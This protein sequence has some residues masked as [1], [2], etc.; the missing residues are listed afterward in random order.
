MMERRRHFRGKPRPG[1]RVQLT[2]GLVE[3]DTVGPRRHAVT[4]N[5]GVGGAFI[6]VDNPPPA[7]TTVELE[8]AMPANAE[9]GAGPIAVRAEVR[10]SV[11]D[12]EV[13]MGVKFA[14]LEVEQLLRLNEYFASLA[15]SDLFEHDA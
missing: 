1:R 5:I 6:L 9:S 15:P 13:G 8:L 12:G 2:F 7:G 14:P 3:N 11:T 4:K 10:W